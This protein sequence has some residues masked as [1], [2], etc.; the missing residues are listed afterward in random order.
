MKPSKRI[1]I[2]IWD[3]GGETADRYTVAITGIQWDTETKVQR[4]TWLAA[5]ERPFHP[6]GV[7]M[8]C[9]ETPVSAYRV[10]ECRHL[11]K[12]IDLYELPD[13]VRRFIAQEIAP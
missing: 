6:Q 11:G 9:S 5:S 2:D 12:R 10:S 8:H 7:G 4:V 13:D 3:N 1:T